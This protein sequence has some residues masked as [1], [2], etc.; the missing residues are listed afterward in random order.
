M[1]L[2]KAKELGADL[3]RG[4]R[5][6]NDGYFCADTAESVNVVLYGRTDVE[7]RNR[8][9]DK[10]LKGMYYVVEFWQKGKP[11]AGMSSTGFRRKDKSTHNLKYLMCC[12]LNLSD[13]L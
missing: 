12:F 2:E 10:D 4:L 7:G 9:E 5:Y 1:S 13:G 8:L 6:G 11:V 3:L